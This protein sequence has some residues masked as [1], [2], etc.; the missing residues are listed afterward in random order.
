MTVKRPPIILISGLVLGLLGAALVMGYVRNV[1]S[2]AGAAEQ[3]TTVMVA[4]SAIPTGTA[5]ADA[6]AM[7]TPSKVPARYAR[8]GSIAELDAVAGQFTVRR[9]E[10]G[11]TLSTRDFASAAKTAG[12]LAIPAGREA[13]AVAVPLDG[14]VGRYPRPGDKVSV[15]ATFKEGG[16]STH[17]IL[18]DIQVL[19][20]QPAGSATGRLDAGGTDAAAA[21]GSQLVYLLA[22]T[23]EEATHLVHGRQNGDI[24]LTLVPEGQPSPPVPGVTNP[25]LPAPAPGPRR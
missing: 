10:P 25:G 13:V 11:E 20:T 18:G 12:A 22:V 24:W 2:R 16:A 4:S 3:L 23:P 5:A 7:A 15:Y 9:I 8:P 17:K 6:A 1:E 19:A 14:G 21:A